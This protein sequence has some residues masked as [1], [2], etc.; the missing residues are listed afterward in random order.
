MVRA[1]RTPQVLEMRGTGDYPVIYRAEK[2]EQ[3][4]FSYVT[5]EVPRRRR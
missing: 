4:G 3:A 2:A 5:F 1:S